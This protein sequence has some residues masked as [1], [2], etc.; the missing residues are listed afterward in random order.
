MVPPL[1]A[2]E[3]HF[4]S[5]A[6]LEAFDDA[7][8]EQF[9]AI[10]AAKDKLADLDSLR[11]E[12]MA[13]GKIS[14]QVISHACAPGG[15]SPEMCRQGNDQLAA[16]VRKNKAHF[17][18]FAVLPIADPDECA[19]ELERSVKDLGFV[20]ALID[21]HVNGKYFDG[22]EYDVMWRKAEELDVPIY[23][24]PTWPAEDMMQQ[25]YTGNFTAGASRSLGASG[26]GWHSETGL[27]ILR[28]YAAGVF[29]K[30][31]RLKIII[32]HFG[33]MLP[34]ML[35]RISKL[36]VRW[37]QQRRKILQVWEENIWITTSG[38]WSLDP[39]KCILGNTKIDHILF[40]VDYP[41]EPNENGL[42]WIQDLEDSGLVTQEELEM[43]AYK[44][45]EKLLKVKAPQITNGVH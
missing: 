19:K 10:P 21:N 4:L 25:S 22:D 37:G 36:S 17:A 18:G 3:E 5:T 12:E 32:G 23:L 8:Q 20:G 2:L 16:A 33:E 31:P 26:W 34:F 29:D 40:S 9:K 11:L 42:K 7:Y 44:N 35:Q 30:F 45:A 24:H 14:M 39:L 27:H 43:I 28:L 6:V 1:I 41:F 13:K 15:P 38:V